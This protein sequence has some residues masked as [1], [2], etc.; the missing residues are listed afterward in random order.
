MSYTCQQCRLVNGSMHKTAWIPS[1]FAV[2]SKKIEIDD[3]NG[4][5]ERWIVEEV[6]GAT[7]PYNEVNERSQDYKRTR[8]ASDI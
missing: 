8:E 5:R 3:P 7:L 6:F 2:K 1:A 4:G